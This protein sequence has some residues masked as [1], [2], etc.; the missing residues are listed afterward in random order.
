[1]HTDRTI[2]ELCMTDDELSYSGHDENFC[3]GFFSDRQ[4]AEKTAEHYLKEVE[5]FKDYDVSC[6][7]NE[8]TL[9]G[10]ADSTVI[11]MVYGWNING[12]GDETD[13]TE[14]I[15]YTSQTDAQRALDEMKRRFFR[16][17]WCIDRYTLDECLWQEGF[18]R[19]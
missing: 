6:V 8:K 10:S 9:K 14:S 11:Y 4:T 15:C 19:V 17:E 13:V 1:M 5:G 12:S 2:Y 16:T 18:V 7:I 3:I